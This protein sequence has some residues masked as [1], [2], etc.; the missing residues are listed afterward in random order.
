MRGRRDRAPGAGRLR[1]VLDALDAGFLEGEQDGLP[2]LPMPT[3]SSARA[4]SLPPS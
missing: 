3:P 2:D 4:R 1:P